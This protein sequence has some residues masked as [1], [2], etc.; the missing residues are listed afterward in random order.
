MQLLE[1]ATHVCIANITQYML[2]RMELHPS[3]FVNAAV[4]TEDMVY[5]A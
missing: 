4:R 1:R 3:K 2:Q 5:G